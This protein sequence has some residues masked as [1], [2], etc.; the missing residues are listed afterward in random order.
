MLIQ[1]GSFYFFIYAVSMRSYGYSLSKSTLNLGSIHQTYRVFSS[2]FRAIRPPAQFSED[3]ARARWWENM[4]L[5]LEEHQ[6]PGP[7]AEDSSSLIGG[8]DQHLHTCLFP[9]EESTPEEMLS[10]SSRFLRG[11]SNRDKVHELQI[12]FQ[13]YEAS[14]ASEAFQ[15]SEAYRALKASEA[16]KAFEA[17]KAYKASDACE[18][19]EAFEDYTA[20]EAAEA[21][22]AFE[23]SKAYKAFKASEA[24]EASK[25]F[26]VS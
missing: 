25:V 5:I 21:H 1:K 19:F 20:S 4:E 6:R 7:R 8:N 3:Q 26:E 11:S 13:D 15:V 23:A 10:E 22:K 14:E 12:C 24:Y 18:R 9:P 16:Y 17:P 2:T